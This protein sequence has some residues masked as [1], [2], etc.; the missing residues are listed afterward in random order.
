[1]GLVR[2]LSNLRYHEG[3]SMTEHLNQLEHIFNQLTTMGVEFND[4]MQALWLMG[5]L[6]ES[7]ETLCVSLSNSSVNMALTK[8]ATVNALLNEEVRR[9]SNSDGSQVTSQETLMYDHKKKGKKVKSFQSKTKSTARDKKGDQCH[10]CNKTGHWKA[11]CY[12]LKKDQATGNVKPRRNDNNL[13]V[14]NSGGDLIVV[15]SGDVVSQEGR[16]R[17]QARRRRREAG[18]QP[19]DGG[20]A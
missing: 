2:Q 14:V 11:E 18:D 4:E 17:H 9:R 5:T 12:T 10:Y 3:Q 13:A 1:M 16:R 7:W 8:Q 20:D 6:P 19:P 15:G